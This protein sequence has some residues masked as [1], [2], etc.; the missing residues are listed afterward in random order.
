MKKKNIILGIF[1]T[2]LLLS[3]VFR[4]VD[5]SRIRHNKKPLFVVLVKKYK[6]G[7]SK[8]YLGLGYKV[9]RCHNL[10]GNNSQNI[11][12][13]TMKVDNVCINSSDMYTLY[14]KVID[15]LINGGINSEYLS[16]NLKSFKYLDE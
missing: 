8:E 2:I 15:N 11:G 1:L 4:Y 6:D 16:I 3:I 13:Y 12:F 7:G 9:I 10:S 5:F 14:H